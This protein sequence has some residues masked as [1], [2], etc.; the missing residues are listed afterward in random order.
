ML[1]LFCTVAFGLGSFLAPL[2][3]L[4]QQPLKPPTVVEYFMLLPAKYFEGLRGPMLHP[5]REPVVD[6]QNGYLFAKGDGAQSD[7]CVKLFQRSDGTCV[8]A[9]SS[10]DKEVLSTFLVF[11]LYENGQPRDVTELVMPVAFDDQLN[12]ELPR[13]GTTIRVTDAAGRARYELV[14]NG[15]VFLLKAP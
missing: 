8:V 9:V 3:P 14:W 4:A 5:R 12:Y 13:R 6:I 7:V 15:T 1:R 10:N 2:S 11:H